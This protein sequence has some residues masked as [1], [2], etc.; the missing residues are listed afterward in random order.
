MNITLQQSDYINT[1]G[2]EELGE[3]DERREGK[4][5]SQNNGGSEEN[6]FKSSFGVVA[7]TTARSPTQ[8]CSFGL[9]KDGND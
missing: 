9:E 2:L 7:A 5:N 4:K 8:T 3:G 6:D 1:F